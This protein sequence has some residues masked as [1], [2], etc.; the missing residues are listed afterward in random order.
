MNEKDCSRCPVTGFVNSDLYCSQCRNRP[1]ISGEI[2]LYRHGKFGPVAS[3]RVEAGGII[4]AT[5]ELMRE[6][7]VE[8]I[9]D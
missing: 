2:Y 3:M 6:F 7:R 9:V 5:R 4:E 1:K 8:F